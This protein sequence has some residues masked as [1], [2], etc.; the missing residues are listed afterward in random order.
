VI[1]AVLAVL[2][3]VASL[4]LLDSTAVIE[5]FKAIQRFDPIALA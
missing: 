5:V 1:A 2:T 3:P 4:M